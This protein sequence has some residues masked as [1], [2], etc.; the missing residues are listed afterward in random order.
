MCRPP[1]PSEGALSSAWDVIE[2]RCHLTAVHVRKW[3]F[4]PVSQFGPRPLLAKPDIAI[5]RLLLAVDHGASGTPS[6]PSL[7][8]VLDKGG[9]DVIGG[10]GV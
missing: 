4:A 2:R 1:T 5:C 6:E 8:G 7:R 10:V 3:P 9:M